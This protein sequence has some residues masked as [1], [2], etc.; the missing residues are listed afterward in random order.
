M[1]FLSF[2]KPTLASQAAD[3]G[4]SGD[5]LLSFN[6]AEKN[7]ALGSLFGSTI[8]GTAKTD[9]M[10]GLAGRNTFY[11][12]GG[13]DALLG[14]IGNDTLYGDGPKTLVSK[15]VNFAATTDW[16]Q[17][18][19]QDHN[20]L[21][22]DGLTIKSVGGEL[23]AWRGL[24]V[25]SPSDGL[26]SQ[27]WTKEIDFYNDTKEGLH[28][29]FDSAQ[30]NVSIVL[31]A[32]Q[33]EKLAIT[34]P[35]KADYTIYFTDGTSKQGSILAASTATEH[36]FTIDSSLTGGKMI[37]GVDLSPSADLSELRPGQVRNPD[38]YIQN[39]P[40][41]EFTVKAVNYAASSEDSPGDDLLA[42]AWATTGS[43]AAA[44][45]TACSAATAT[46]SSKAAR[47]T[48]SW[49]AATAAT[50]SCSPSTRR[51]TT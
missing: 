9:I 45:T 4:V 49:S 25:S 44:A 21:S 32:F 48:T 22:L 3:R 5:A 27:G 13:N 41:S 40:F 30:S 12:N 31:G 37:A 24:S 35:E 17:N 11:G 16:T 8:N 43:W 39:H 42:A 28:F 33:I 50:R 34:Q 2:L 7:Y 6:T 20:T 26:A 1:S 10:V 47:A 23:A 38:S 19:S 29:S 51:V 46:T 36:T 14:G 18:L 15:S